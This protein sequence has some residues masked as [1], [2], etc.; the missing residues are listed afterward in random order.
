LCV[1]VKMRVRPAI[2]AENQ[3]GEELEGDAAAHGIRKGGFGGRA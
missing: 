3:A 1:L 2:A